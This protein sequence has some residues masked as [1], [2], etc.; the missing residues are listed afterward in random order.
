MVARRQ[1]TLLWFFVVSLPL[2]GS[3]C[4]PTWSLSQVAEASLA[5]TR[6]VVQTLIVLSVVQLLTAL[7]RHI[8]GRMLYILLLVMP[9]VGVLM[10][11][12]ANQQATRALSRAGL[13]IGLSGVP[14]EQVVRLLG[15]YRCRACGRSLIGN[16]SGRCPECGTPV[17]E[18]WRTG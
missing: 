10:P 9:Y 15:L 5:I 3:F 6:L 2:N 11:L 13:R 7:R 12:A 1:R 4:L 16:T 8:L 14:D 17:P 18:V